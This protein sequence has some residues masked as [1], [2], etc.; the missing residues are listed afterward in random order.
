[1]LWDCTRCHVSFPFHLGSLSIRSF[2]R[3]HPILKNMVSTGHNCRRCLRSPCLY[4]LT[5]AVGKLLGSTPLY[6]HISLYTIM[7]S[8]LVVPYSL[9]IGQVLTLLLGFGLS[10]LAICAR[11]YTKVRIDRR[12]LI[13]DYE[14]PLSC[15][16]TMTLLLT[17]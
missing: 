8:D 15:R 4:R 17:R 16:I 3:H 2:E 11:V 9:R 7:P 1:V 10:T 5:I 14:W 13:E 6:P 12:M